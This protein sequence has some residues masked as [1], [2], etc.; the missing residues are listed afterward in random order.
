MCL[1]RF[2]LISSLLGSPWAFLVGSPALTALSV[3]LFVDAA[4]WSHSVA[5]VW[6]PTVRAWDMRRGFFFLLV[7]FVS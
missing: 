4:I 3:R 1:N 6:L 5:Q 7:A 2:Q